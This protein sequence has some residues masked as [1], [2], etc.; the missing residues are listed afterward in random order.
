MREKGEGEEVEG[1]KGGEGGDGEEGR[2]VVG[3][4]GGRGR[5]KV[6]GGK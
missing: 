3:E 1:G 6:V 5:E 2:V 4:G